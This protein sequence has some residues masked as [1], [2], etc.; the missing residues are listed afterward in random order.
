MSMSPKSMQRIGVVLSAIPALM[1]LMSATMKL[2]HQPELV[3]GFAA[4]GFA[5]SLLTPIGLV[6]LACAV[7]YL[8]PQTAVLGAILVTAY[9]GGAVVTHVRI[10]DAFISP[11]VIGV[12][13]WAGLYLRDPRIRE[14]L[15]LRR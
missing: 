1:L 3:Q 14:L 2:S 5:E 10:G 8:I 15:P 6:C 4:F 11:I 13:V 7:L 9:L 12:V